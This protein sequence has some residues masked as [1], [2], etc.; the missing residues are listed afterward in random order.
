[1]LKTKHVKQ[2]LLVRKN[3]RLLEISKKCVFNY[4]IY[5]YF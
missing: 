4:S 3:I 1:M 2:G 5:L